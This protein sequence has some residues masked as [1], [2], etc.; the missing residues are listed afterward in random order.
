MLELLLMPYIVTALYRKIIN[1]QQSARTPD[2]TVNGGFGPAHV[3]QF[4]ASPL[5]ADDGLVA[6]YRFSIG[7]LP[8]WAN[9]EVSHF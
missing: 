5:D 9:K 6:D 7:P 8:K 3:D 2:Q 1:H 4:D